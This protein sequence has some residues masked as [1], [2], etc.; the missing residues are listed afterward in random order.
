MSDHDGTYW[1]SLTRLIN[2]TNR[3]TFIDVGA[4]IG[5]FT[6]K[7]NRDYPEATIFAFEPTPV[8]F[9]ALREKFGLVPKINLINA[10]LWDT[11]GEINFEVHENSTHFRRRY[12]AGRNCNNQRKRICRQRQ[13][14]LRSRRRKFGRVAD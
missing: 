8:A 1:K 14:L 4:N 5:A 12:F 10:A 6:E 9:K 3:Q 7:L 13:S 2:L 11:D